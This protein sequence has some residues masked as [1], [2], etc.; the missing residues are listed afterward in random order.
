[1]N[2]LFSLFSIYLSVHPSSCQ[3][4]RR[5]TASLSHTLKETYRVSPK[6]VDRLC[7]VAANQAPLPASSQVLSFKAEGASGRRSAGICKQKDEGIQIKKRGDN[8]VERMDVSRLLS[9]KAQRAVYRSS[10]VE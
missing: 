7:F 6:T 1:M 4:G 8:Q 3:P 9:S 2:A 5:W 10:A